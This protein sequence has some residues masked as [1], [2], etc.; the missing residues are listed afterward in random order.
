MKPIPIST[1]PLLAALALF[2][3]GAER[4]PAQ[5]AGS[6]RGGAQKLLPAIKTP[7]D[8]Q[9]VQPGDTIV[10]ACPKCKT[11]SYTYV[12]KTTRGATPE[13]KT[14]AK[15]LCPGCETTLTTKGRGKQ[16]VEQIVH[17]CKKCG[18]KNAFCCVMKKGAGPTKGMEEEKK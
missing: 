12:E 18:S 11:I 10:M 7:Q 17:V 16:A 14:G 4:L 1:L 3:A 5:E 2:G 6:A 9:A 15:H 13:T 8:A